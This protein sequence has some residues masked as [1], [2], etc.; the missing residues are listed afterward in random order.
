[1]STTLSEEVLAA[2]QFPSVFAPHAFNLEGLDDAMGP[3]GREDGDEDT[4]LACT[5]CEDC[6]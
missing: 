3:F 2:D 5:P 1:M 4:A 6:L